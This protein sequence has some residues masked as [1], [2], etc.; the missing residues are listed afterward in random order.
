MKEYIT[1]KQAVAL[2]NA[3][4]VP[5]TER[6]WGVAFAR[7]CNA[8]IQAY[9]DNIVAGVVLPEPV[10]YLAWKEGKPCWEGDDCVCEDAVYPVCSDDDRTSKAIHTADQLRQAIADA[11]ARQVPQGYK[12][13]PVTPTNDMTVA[14]ANALEDPENERSSWDLAENMY[15][16]MLA[17]AQDPK[18]AV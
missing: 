7:L 9:R 13:V 2:A 12:L 11:L 8:A 6:H 5:I 16:E 4:G 10:G 17:A 1:Q 3:A 14:M 15:S 18:E